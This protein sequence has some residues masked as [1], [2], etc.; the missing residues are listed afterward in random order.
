[1]ASWLI[2][3]PNACEARHLTQSFVPDI[4][5]ASLSATVHSSDWDKLLDAS[6]LMAAV[7]SFWHGREFGKRKIIVPRFCLVQIPGG[8]A[9]LARTVH[10]GNLLLLEAWYS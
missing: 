3:V 2:Y 8:F 4:R 10:R 7:R 9:G 5:I 1:M 6:V